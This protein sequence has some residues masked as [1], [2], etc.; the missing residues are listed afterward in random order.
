MDCMD[1]MKMMAVE[2]INAFHGM[3]VLYET[4][5]RDFTLVRYLDPV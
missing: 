3:N 5:S 4:A 2:I 1:C